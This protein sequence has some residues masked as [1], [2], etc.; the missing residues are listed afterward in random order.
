MQKDQAYE[1]FYTSYFISDIA[2][3]SIVSVFADKDQ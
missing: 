1:T 2:F 3:L